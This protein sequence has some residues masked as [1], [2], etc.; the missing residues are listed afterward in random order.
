[1][2]C[3]VSLPNTSILLLYG[4]RSIGRPGARSLSGWQPLRHDV[5]EQIVPDRPIRVG[6]EVLRLR[7]ELA[8]RRLI[9]HPAGGGGTRRSSPGR[10]LLGRE[11]VQVERHVG[12]AVT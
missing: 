9:Q 1:M 6:L 11:G 2:A 12:E 5:L 4:C 10:E 8:I 7:E 3:H